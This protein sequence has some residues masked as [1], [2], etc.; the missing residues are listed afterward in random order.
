MT[1]ISQHISDLHR[2]PL[3]LRKVVSTSQSSQRPEDV[4]AKLSLLT[5]LLLIFELS[6][7]CMMIGFLGIAL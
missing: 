2:P 3:L 5:L 7:L 6:R 1:F 4:G